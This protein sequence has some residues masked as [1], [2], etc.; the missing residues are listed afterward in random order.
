[1]RRVNRFSRFA[2]QDML[3]ARTA[4]SL[5]VLCLV[6][7]A[8]AACGS[9]PVL[10]SVAASASGADSSTPL[11]SP[12]DAWQSFTPTTARYTIGLPPGWKA[13][14]NPTLGDVL[15]A[16]DG[17]GVGV[18][19]EAQRRVVPL[20][21]Y[22]EAFLDASRRDGLSE[23][24]HSADITLAGR[25]AKSFEYHHPFAGEPRFLQ[26]ALTVSGST[27][28]QVLLYTSP[29]TESNDRDFFRTLIS[30]FTLK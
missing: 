14:E 4:R 6:A 22:V 20:T 16:P 23:P 2:L 21:A 5:A 10:P 27:G 19:A 26:Y 12:I 25:P 17:S 15:I 8:L 18:I 29:G 3:L 9:T 11:S 1:M 7:L 30:T 13:V 28:W 24:E